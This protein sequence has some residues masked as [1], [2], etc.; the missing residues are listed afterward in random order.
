MNS[1]NDLCERNTLCVAL[2][3]AIRSEPARRFR[4]PIIRVRTTNGAEWGDPDSRY[5]KALPGTSCCRVNRSGNWWKQ[6]KPAVLDRSK[7]NAK[8]GRSNEQTDKTRR[9]RLGWAT[10]PEARSNEETREHVRS[11]NNRRLR[12]ACSDGNHT[13]GTRLSFIQQ[14]LIAAVNNGRSFFG[15][16]REIPYGISIVTSDSADFSNAPSKLSLPHESGY[17]GPR[18][19]RLISSRTN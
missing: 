16:F 2:Q 14:A 3:S 4:S 6:A 5:R 11:R 1:H 13:D 17:N 15:G 8:I 19:W 10:R 7:F 18:H 9:D 12:S